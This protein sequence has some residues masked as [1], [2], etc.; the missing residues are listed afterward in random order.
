M[1]IIL[2]VIV[3]SFAAN[4]TPLAAWAESGHV[5]GTQIKK[6]HCPMHPQVVSDKPGDCPICHMRLVPGGGPGDSVPSTAPPLEGRVPV[7]ISEMAGKEAGIQTETV[8]KFLFCPKERTAHS[9][10]DKRFAE[11]RDEVSCNIDEET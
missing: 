5:H 8:N 4:F 6:Y 11:A 10:R 9:Q 7:S 2:P 1:R 3:L